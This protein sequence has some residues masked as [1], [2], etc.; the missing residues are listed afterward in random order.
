M[1]TEEITS[2]NAV[3][4]PSTAVISPTVIVKIGTEGKEYILHT[5]LLKHHSGYFRGALSGA[6]KE[7]D[8]GVIPIT[9]IETDAFDTFVD[10][11]YR[12]TVNTEPQSP[13]NVLSRSYILADRLIMPGLKSALMDHYYHRYTGH[14]LAV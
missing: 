9:D 12:G 11:I 6:F 8:D 10:W 7:T 1:A 5:E 3:L 4:L 14:H 2:S 13:S